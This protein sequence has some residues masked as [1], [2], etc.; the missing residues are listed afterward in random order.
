MP[1]AVYEEKVADLEAQKASHLENGP[2]LALHGAET[3]EDHKHLVPMNLADANMNG[4]LFVEGVEGV[5]NED[6]FQLCNT[7]RGDH[8]KLCA[9]FGENF[10]VEYRFKVPFLF[11]GYGLRTAND[12]PSR[13]PETWTIEAKGASIH[14]GE[15]NEEFEMVHEGNLGEHAEASSSDDD[16]EGRKRW[17]LF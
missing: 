2:Q 5:G 10:F 14:T 3:C 15:E 4:H 16:D 11:R 8:N 17:K 6:V 7:H 13:D 1:L 12:E 9:P